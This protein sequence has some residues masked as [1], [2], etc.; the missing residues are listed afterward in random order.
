MVGLGVRIVSLAER[1]KFGNSAV[2]C[3]DDVRGTDR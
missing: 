1:I 3:D 2:D